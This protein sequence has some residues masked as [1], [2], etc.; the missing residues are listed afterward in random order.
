[1]SRDFD[2]F[3]QRGRLVV[4]TERQ[5]LDLPPPSL[6]GAHQFANAGLAIAALLALED[7][8]IDEA[9]IARGVSGAVWPGR[10]Q[11]L[12][13]GP[14]AEIARDAGADVWLDGAHNPHAG[15]A[16]AEASQ[17]LALRDGRPVVL[18]VGMLGR[19]DARGFFA[20]FSDLKP[21]VFATGFHS[22]SATPAETLVAAARSAGLST[23]PASGVEAAV[24][25][26]LGEGRPA[27]HI[28]IC[29]SLHF[30]GDVLAMSPETWPT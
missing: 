10:F 18:I 23:T 20:A 26:A 13:M 1:M 24:R 15:V 8:R 17:R 19:K 11:R 25:A 29:G 21:R 28:I 7:P 27:P 3:E 14:I 22:P 16:L 12:T 2:A 6:F 4:Q 30:I 5:L 9:Q